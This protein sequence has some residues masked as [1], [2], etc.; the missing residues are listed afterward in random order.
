MSRIRMMIIKAHSVSPRPQ[1]Q[2]ATAREWLLSG[3]TLASTVAEAALHGS[4][5]AS[6][7]PQENAMFISFQGRGP[8]LRPP[9]TLYV[10]KRML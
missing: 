3:K 10:I 9:S 1:K 5:E 8:I 6:N 4:N 2:P 7:T